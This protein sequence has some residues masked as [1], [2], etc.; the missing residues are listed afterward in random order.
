MITRS[1]GNS[2]NVRCSLSDTVMVQG[3][4]SEIS[5][6]INA[7]APRAAPAT[8]AIN[9][10]PTTFPAFVAAGAPVPVLVPVPLPVGRVVVPAA[11]PV[12]A[13]VVPPAPVDAEPVCVVPVSVPFV[14]DVAKVGVVVASE[15]FQQDRYDADVALVSVPLYAGHPGMVFG[16]ARPP[17]QSRGSQISPV[18]GSNQCVMPS[19][20]VVKLWMPQTERAGVAR[21]RIA[22]AERTDFIL[23]LFYLLFG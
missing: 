6:Q 23:Q 11:V 7:A 16:G 22:R 8:T 14:V 20:Q 18:R 12:G 3:W 19:S 21:A 5:P 4:F 13:A 1:L 9:F 10:A 15:G 2:G 17:P